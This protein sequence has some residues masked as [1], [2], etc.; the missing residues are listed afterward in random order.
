M[1][2]EVVLDAMHDV[3]DMT[4]T[5]T[6]QVLTSLQIVNRGAASLTL[7]V[8]DLEI[9]V[10]VDE[11]LD[12]SYDLFSTFTILATGAYEVLVRGLVQ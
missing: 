2:R 4:Y 3:T 6:E 5:S 11:V 12:E 7:Q 8:N 10:D 1:V 9:T